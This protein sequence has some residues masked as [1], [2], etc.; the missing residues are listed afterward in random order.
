MGEGA[1]LRGV[2]HDCFLIF[3]L[4]NGPHL[5]YHRWSTEAHPEGPKGGSDGAHAN[6]CE[7]SIAQQFSKKGRRLVVAPHRWT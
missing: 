7:I 1:R 6:N 4:S 3:N 2:S 5:L